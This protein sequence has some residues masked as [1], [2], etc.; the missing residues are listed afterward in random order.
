MPRAVA[1]D[2][3]TVKNFEHR[4]SWGVD[5]LA[6]LVD[7]FWGLFWLS[8]LFSGMFA[9]AFFIIQGLIIIPTFLSLA[10]KLFFSPRFALF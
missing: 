3:L 9:L 4:K 7:V 2:Y 8:R 5:R 6:L 1:E 10:S